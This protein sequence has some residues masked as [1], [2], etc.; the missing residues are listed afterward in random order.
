LSAVL[1]FLNGLGPS[2]ILIGAGL[3]LVWNWWKGRS[4]SPNDPQKALRDAL[5][6]LLQPPPEPAKPAPDPKPTVPVP[7]DERERLILSLMKILRR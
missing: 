1:P 2:G 5:L 7:D 3:V 4:G 6:S